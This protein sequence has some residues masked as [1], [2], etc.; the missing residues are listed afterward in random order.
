VPG[1]PSE[2][3]FMNA[4]SFPMSNEAWKDL[5][6]RLIAC[7]AVLWTPFFYLSAYRGHP[8]PGAALIE[9]GLLFAIPSLILAL[10]MGPHCGIRRVAIFTVT[11]CLFLDLQ[12]SRFDGAI[13]YGGAIGIA[14]ICWAMRE[15]LALIVVCV[16]TTI[17]ASSLGTKQADPYVDHM[18]V[19]GNSDVGTSN[20]TTSGPVVHLI[21]D[22]FSGISGIPADLAGGTELRSEL[23][24]FF[25]SYDFAVAENAISEYA[26][27]RYSISGILNFEASS[28]PDRLVHGKRPYILKSN[29]YFERLHR[30]GLRLHV[31][32]ST[33]MDFCRESPIPIASCFT[34]RYD[35]TDWLRTSD[36]D[37]GQ[38]LSVLLG[39]YLNMPGFFESVWKGYVG[40]RGLA[41]N[42]GLSLPAIME[43]DGTL[44]P[45]VTLPVFDRMSEDL[46][47]APKGTAH[48]AHLLM[49]H[50]PFV[51]DAQCV[52]RP[53][54]FDWLGSHPLHRKDTT[55]EGREVRYSQYFVQ[56]RCTTRRLGRLFDEM[57]GDGRWA[58]TEIIIH[59]DHGA[60][61]FE[62]APRTKNR[63]RLTP[64]DLFGAFGTLFA[65]KSAE[66]VATA[67]QRTLPISRLLANWSGDESGTEIDR[68]EEPVVVYLEGKNDDPWLAIPYPAET[69]ESDSPTQ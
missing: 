52:P 58:E 69:G 3:Q 16:F 24:E 25:R 42:A 26:A 15:H 51:Y 10:L 31:Y 7:F 56:V 23:L 28:D 67:T 47:S 6:L 8:A 13:A 38:K 61:I 17:F 4:R 62:T 44:A 48:F 33:Y 41:E 18:I 14:V 60:R 50:G 55:T 59:G 49:P 54:P 64:Q 22:G 27:S 43:W 9:S 57:K 68:E 35:G 20:A 36:L 65:V 5:G 19:G 12:V 37:D 53:D 46:A 39:L 29:A 32:Q 2:A 21:L 40:L 30:R 11:I 34:Y 1:A 63:D 45:I 66:R